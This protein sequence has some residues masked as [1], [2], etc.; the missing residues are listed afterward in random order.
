MFTRGDRICSRRQ[1][2]IL[3]PL[4]RCG[5]ERVEPKGKPLGLRV[6]TRRTRTQIQAAEMSF[7]SKVVRMV[8]TSSRNVLLKVL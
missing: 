1:V 4:V 5:K 2:D 6:V 3:G 8:F 7:F